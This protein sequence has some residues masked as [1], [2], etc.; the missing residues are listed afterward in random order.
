MIQMWAD[1]TL[2]TVPCQFVPLTYW[3]LRWMVWFCEG[4]EKLSM[5]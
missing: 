2:K 5:T 3:K 1:S 4:S